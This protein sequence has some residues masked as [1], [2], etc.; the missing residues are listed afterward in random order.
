MRRFNL[1]DARLVFV[2]VSIKEMTGLNAVMALTSYLILGKFWRLYSRQMRQVII[3]CIYIFTIYKL[4]K[5]GL[6]G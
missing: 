6:W 1:H 2:V 5:H 3:L 4:V